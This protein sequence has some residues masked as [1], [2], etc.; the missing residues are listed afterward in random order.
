MKRLKKI[1]IFLLCVAAMLVVVFMVGR[2]GCKLGGFNA[3]ETAGIEQIDVEE[4]HVRICG[5]YPGSFPRGFLG[6]HAEQVDHTLYVGFK[7]ST[8]FGIFETGDFD[9]TIPTKGTVTQVVIKSSDHEYTI[10]PQEDEFNISE[11]E[12]RIS[13]NGI[14]TKDLEDG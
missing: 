7:F 10:W 1:L 5:F 9:I 6:Y 8:L 12:P 4:D 14:E 11:A 2:Y 3:C 13:V